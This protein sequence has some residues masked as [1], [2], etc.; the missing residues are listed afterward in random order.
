MAGDDQFWTDVH[1]KGAPR[2]V[3]KVTVAK[4][5]GDDLEFVLSDDTKDRMGDV[6]DA[7]GWVLANFKKNPIA[8]FNHSSNFPIGTWTNV[9]VEGKRLVGNLKL[10]AEGTSDRIDEILRL[11]E[12]G[13]LRAVSVGFSSIERE[14]LADNSGILFKRQELLET[15]LVSVP[16][17]PKAVQLARSLHVSDETIDLVFGKHANTH[18]TITRGSSGEHA[19]IPPVRK[20]TLMT[21]PLAQRIE[22]AQEKLVT[23]RDQ[24]TNHLAETGDEPDEAAVA[25][26]EE[27]NTRL[28]AQR[29][30]LESLQAVEREMASQASTA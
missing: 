13:I 3:R 16:A 14:A 10:A 12:Q 22:N 18:G 9:R 28:A 8:L 25:V 27:L 7:K 19:A 1:V 20:D 24:L 26:T 6:I 17:N 5:A 23:I 15:S 29:R 11:V 2:L 30:N 21:T 4:A